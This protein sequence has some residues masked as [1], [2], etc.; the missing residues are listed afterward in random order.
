LFLS[1]HFFSL[2]TFFFWRYPHVCVYINV[3]CFIIILLTANNTPMVWLLIDF[4]ILKVIETRF[5]SS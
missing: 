5:F 4:F 1:N 3:P 2:S